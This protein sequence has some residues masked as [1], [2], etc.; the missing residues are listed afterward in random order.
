MKKIVKILMLL[1]VV[2][3]FT[4]SGSQA[5]IVIRARLGRPGPVVVRPMRPSPHHV[6]VSEE[7][8]PNGGT[9][10]Y[11]QGYWVVPAHPGAVWIA[12]HWRHRR[13]GYFWVPGHWSV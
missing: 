10:V 6:W 3:L 1:S 4:V 13:D 2:S 5:Q 11:H 12:G 8:V 7:W 9:Y